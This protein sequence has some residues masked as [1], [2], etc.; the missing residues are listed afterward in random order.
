MT[1]SLESQLR[2]AR[3][4]STQWRHNHLI[5]LRHWRSRFDQQPSTFQARRNNGQWQPCNTAHTCPVTTPRTWEKSGK[6][7]GCHSITRGHESPHMMH[8]EKIV[9]WEFDISYSKPDGFIHYSL[10]LRWKKVRNIFN[11]FWVWLYPDWMCGD[12]WRC[13]FVH[14]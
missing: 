3:R 4:T 13:S 14:N 8:F 9:T 1:F 10:W 6:W 7:H 2:C 5:Y 12:T 11:G